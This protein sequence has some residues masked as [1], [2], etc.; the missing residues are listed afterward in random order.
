MFWRTPSKSKGGQMKIILALMVLLAAANASAQTWIEQRTDV[1]AATTPRVDG[2]IS[3]NSSP[4]V[5]AF[6]WFQ[7]DRSYAE[8]YVGPSFSL[9]P[10]LQFG[11]GAGVEQS[12]HPL[13][14]G[15]FAWMGHQ[16]TSLLIITEGLGSGLWYKMEFNW[17]VANNLGFGLLT[18]RFKGVGPRIQYLVPHTPLTIWSAA[19]HSPTGNR[20]VIGIR[21]K[22]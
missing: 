21:T 18:E 3:A 5:G 11:A 14:L 15:S 16:K 12:D 19:L 4:R 10:W 8:A 6:A 9:K 22:M 20:V 1:A 2:W 17:K 13:R 7:A